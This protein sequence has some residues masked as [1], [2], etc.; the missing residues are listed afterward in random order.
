MLNVDRYYDPL[1]AMIKHAAELRFIRPA[2][3]GAILR[4]PNCCGRNRAPEIHIP[5]ARNRSLSFETA[6][7]VRH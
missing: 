6:P 3:T 1:L 7:A 4:R 2:G 5:P